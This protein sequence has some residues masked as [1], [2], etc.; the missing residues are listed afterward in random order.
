MNWLSELAK[1]V[2]DA[3][4]PL[5][6]SGLKAQDAMSG[7]LAVIDA[8][9][10]KCLFEATANYSREKGHVEPQLLA[11]LFTWTKEKLG[12]QF[13]LPAKC[14]VY[15]YVYNSPCKDC[16]TVLKRISWSVVQ[17]VVWVGKER[18]R[19]GQVEIGLLQ[20]LHEQW[21]WNALR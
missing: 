12:S 17:G 8:K 2:H 4:V 10:E 13:C 9:G 20:V 21:G 19:N 5:V 11:A 7:A 15:L 1:K 14:T 18:K 6:S 16:V 3:L